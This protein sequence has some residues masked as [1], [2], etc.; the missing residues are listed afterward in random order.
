VLTLVL[1][2]FEF[3]ALRFRWDDNAYGSIVWTIVGTHLLHLLVMT[4]EV[5]VILHY[6]HRKGMDDKH[7]RDVRVTAWYWYWVAL[8]W[9]PLYALVFLGPRVL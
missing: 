2:A 8:V 3:P 5:A 9:V 4:L 1:R 7:A 6:I